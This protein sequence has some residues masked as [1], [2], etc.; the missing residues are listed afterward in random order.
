MQVSIGHAGM[1]HVTTESRPDAGQLMTRHCM[2][3]W[4]TAIS[5]HTDSCQEQVQ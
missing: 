3:E 4:W 1:H 2:W 5:T